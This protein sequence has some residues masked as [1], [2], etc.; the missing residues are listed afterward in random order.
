VFT[1]L[2]NGKRGDWLESN[3]RDLSFVNG[4]LSIV[5]EELTAGRQVRNRGVRP[6]EVLDGDN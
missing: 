3:R 1:I 5:N 6:H 4:H 2:K